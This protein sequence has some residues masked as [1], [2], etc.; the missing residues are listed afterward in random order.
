MLDTI[1]LVL[2]NDYAVYDNINEYIRF[3]YLSRCQMKYTVGMVR[4]LL[5]IFIHYANLYCVLYFYFIILSDLI[6]TCIS[7]VVIFCLISDTE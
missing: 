3:L 5:M 7:V 4:M 2:R 6:Y 1:T